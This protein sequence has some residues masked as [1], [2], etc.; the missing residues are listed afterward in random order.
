MADDPELMS[1]F[2]SISESKWL[3]DAPATVAVQCASCQV[4]GRD[5]PRFAEGWLCDPCRVARARNEAERDRFRHWMSEVPAGARDCEFGVNAFERIGA[6]GADI[7]RA[8]A[9][10]IALGSLVLSGPP[11]AGKTSLAAALM[12]FIFEQ[13]SHRRVL[14]VSALKLCRARA[15]HKLGDGDP[16]LVQA[17]MRAELL[18]LDDLGQEKR[19]DL[20]PI[21]DVLFEREEDRSPTWITTGFSAEEIASMYG[22][23][24]LRRV[25][26]RAE[27]IPLFVKGKP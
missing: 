27:Q 7:A 25:Y 4:E 6:K 13:H 2:A 10:A 19:N 23:G 26:G 22:G 17:A 21:T 16:P 15:A 24:V 1:V 12:R 20:N 14:W 9:A 3:S 18:V 5:F 8:K 11:G